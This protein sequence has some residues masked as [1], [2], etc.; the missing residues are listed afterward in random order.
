[1][2]ILT[3]HC[4]DPANRQNLT[5]FHKKDFLTRNQPMLTLSNKISETGWGNRPQV[6]RE[7]LVEMGA[8]RFYERV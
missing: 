3:L 7:A 1:V 2:T 8:V 6:S 5:G 4:I